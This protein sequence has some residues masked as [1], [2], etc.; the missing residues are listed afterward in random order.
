MHMTVD[1]AQGQVPVTI[2]QLHGSLDA[3]NY[4]QAIARARELYAAGTRHLLI[5]L[6]D[7]SFMGSSG[8]VALHSIALLLRGEEPL[9]PETGWRGFHD[10]D[11]DPSLEPQRYVKLLNPQPK[12][13][14]TLE[15]V[16]MNEFFEIY[17]DIQAAIAS[18]V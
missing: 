6:S 1:Q 7:L 13:D 11:R 8:V 14:R 9:D 15:L 3:S 12:I 4:E 5:D 18:F 2:L 10:I 17:T 16:G